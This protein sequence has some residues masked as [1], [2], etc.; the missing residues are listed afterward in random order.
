MSQRSSTI[1]DPRLEETMNDERTIA[2]E[3]SLTDI[4]DDGSDCIN[5]HF[6]S[7]LNIFDNSCI[8]IFGQEY[9][10]KVNTYVDNQRNNG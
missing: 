7:F 1:Q 10:Y 5:L 9:V 8:T 2:K 3:R 6:F 4:T